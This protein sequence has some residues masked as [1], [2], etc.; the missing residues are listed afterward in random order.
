MKKLLL[1]MLLCT[2]TALGMTSNQFLILGYGNT[3]CAGVLQGY[4]AGG[5]D[6]LAYGIWANG[7]LTSNSQL[8]TAVS[9]AASGLSQAD[10]NTRIQQYCKKH[11]RMT[12]FDAADALVRSLR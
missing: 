12:L 7:Y 6:K 1:L 8:S 11:P 5:T 2:T 10:I 3:A 4:D 9:D